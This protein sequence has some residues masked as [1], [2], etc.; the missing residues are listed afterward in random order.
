MGNTFSNEYSGK[1]AKTKKKK[2]KKTKNTMTND[3]WFWCNDSIDS[4]KTIKVM[5]SV[6]IMPNVTFITITP[7]EW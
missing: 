3:E 6:I 4:D 1:K 5:L 7:N 2:K